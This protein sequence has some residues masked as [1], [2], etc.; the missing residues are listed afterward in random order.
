MASDRQFG[1]VV[2][3][4]VDGVA[5]RVHVGVFTSWAAADALVR[6][7]IA[8]PGATPEGTAYTIEDASQVPA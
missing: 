1:W 8:S 4:W 2:L 3:Q 7:L 5:T 6:R